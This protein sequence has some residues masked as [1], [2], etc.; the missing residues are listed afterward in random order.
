MPFSLPFSL[1]VFTDLEAA[2]VQMLVPCPNKRMNTGDVGRGKFVPNPSYV[3]ARHLEM[4]CFVGKAMG[5][6]IRIGN[7]VPLNIPS[8]V[9]KMIVGMKV[10]D[11]IGEPS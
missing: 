4:W 5:V 7:P 9:W 11:A 8:L 1:Q 6:A 3:D 10:R 2:H